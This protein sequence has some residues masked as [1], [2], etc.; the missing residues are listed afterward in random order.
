[1]KNAYLFAIEISQWSDAISPYIEL[2]IKNNSSQVSI[3]VLKKI[4]TN[5]GL[6]AICITGS[7]GE[8]EENT[9]I[10]E[11]TTDCEVLKICNIGAPALDNSL[12]SYYEIRSGVQE[13]INLY[14]SEKQKSTNSMEDIKDS[15]AKFNT[16]TRLA[17]FQATKSSPT[18][19]NKGKKTIISFE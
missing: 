17:S 1:M 18:F 6:L 7:L 14:Q 13:L 15:I 3:N 5:L 10:H 8:H 12:L 9:L 19:L 11:I 2:L 16:M 4:R